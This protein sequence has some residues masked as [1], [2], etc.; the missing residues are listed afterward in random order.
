MKSYLLTS[1]ATGL[2]ALFAAPSASAQ[3]AD[4]AIQAKLDKKFQEISKWAA[5]PAIVG[6]VEKA[7]ATPALPDMNQDK[8]KALGVLDPVVVGLSRNDAAGVVKKNKGKEV[9]EAFVNSKDGC[10]V[11]LLSKTTSW[12]HK[13]AKHTDPMKGKNWQGS[14][15]VDESTQKKQ[16]QISVPVKDAKGNPI[17]SLVV[18]YDVNAL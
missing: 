16:V 14:I 2:V 17:G 18:G 3:A 6:A 13:H 5:D 11:A 10:K 12:C 8:W 7:N 15:E 4:A 1:I 9:S